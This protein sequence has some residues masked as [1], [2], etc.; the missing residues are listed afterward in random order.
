MWSQTVCSLFFFSS[1]TSAKIEI[2]NKN[3]QDKNLHIAFKAIAIMT[4]LLSFFLYVEHYQN[5]MINNSWQ[6][7]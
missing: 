2:V 5:S 4:L 1:T 7:G 3:I 6:Q